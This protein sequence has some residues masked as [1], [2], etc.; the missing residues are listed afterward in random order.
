MPSR[1]PP[2]SAAFA[3]GRP[4]NPGTSPTNYQPKQAYSA[5][6]NPQVNMP[7]VISAA[8]LLN[9]ASYAPER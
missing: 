3:S 6:L 1:T 4:C 8:N 9:A 7:P 5:V 2:P